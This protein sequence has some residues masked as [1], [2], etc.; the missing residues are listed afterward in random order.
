MFHQNAV[1]QVRFD[2][3][4]VHSPWGERAL[5]SVSHARQGDLHASSICYAASR[6]GLRPPSPRASG[7]E[8]PP[9]SGILPQPAVQQVS[10]RP[11]GTRRL[12]GRDTPLASSPQDEWL[13]ELA[14]RLVVTH[15]T[16][17]GANWGTPTRAGSQSVPREAVT[18]RG[19][20]TFPI[21]QGT[22]A[23]G[24]LGL[25]SAPPGASAFPL[26]AAWGSTPPIHMFHV[27]HGL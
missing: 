24:P 21:S 3:D 7:I 11:R 6:F 20:H 9:T 17:S 10:L 4:H 27:K 13:R 18:Q 12:N 2:T 14:P 23:R 16:C 8:A 15:R 5:G 22:V 19:V 26:P 25:I 1:Q